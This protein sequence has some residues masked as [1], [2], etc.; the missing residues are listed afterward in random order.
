MGSVSLSPEGVDY[1][2]SL[3]RI[4]PKFFLKKELTV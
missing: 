1:I 3:L 2:M 4:P